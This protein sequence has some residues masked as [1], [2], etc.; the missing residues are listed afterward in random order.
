MSTAHELLDDANDDLDLLERV[1]T[2]DEA[3]VG[4]WSRCRNQNQIIPMEATKR[5]AKFGQL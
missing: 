2:G 3:W 1:K 5:A 4:M